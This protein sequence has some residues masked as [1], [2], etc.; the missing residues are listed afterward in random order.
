MNL[1]NRVPY[2]LFCAA[3]A[4]CVF[5]GFVAFVLRPMIHNDLWWLQ[6]ATAFGPALL[7]FFIA[8]HQLRTLGLDSSATMGEFAEAFDKKPNHR[9]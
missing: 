7:C 3:L 9:P 4:F 6:I 5:G 1:I 8:N 2:S